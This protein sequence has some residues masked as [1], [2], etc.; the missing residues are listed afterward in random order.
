MSIGKVLMGVMAGV[1][2]GTAIGVLYAPDKGSSTRQKISKKGNKYAEDLGNK[3]NAFV[4][5]VNKKIET[6]NNEVLRMTQNG[7]AKLE[8]AE[9]DLLANSSRQAK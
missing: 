6:V 9:N 8:E 7:K 2:V 3:F 4:E 1:A 5:S